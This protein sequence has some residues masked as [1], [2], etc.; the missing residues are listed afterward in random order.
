MSCGIV[1]AL[2]EELATLTNRKLARGECFSLSNDVLVAY[3]G[4]GPHNAAE[5]ARL[6]IA[7]GADRLI[8]WGCA[9]ALAPELRPG[10][11]VIADR[12]FFDQQ[13]YEADKCWSDKVSSRLGEKL[14]VGNGKL[15]TE[16]RI[17][18]LSEDKQAIHRNTGAM[19]L[20]MESGAIAKV[21]SQSNLPCLVLRAIAD[22]VAL[23]LPPAVSRAMN[24]Q[25]QVELGKLLRHLALHPW[26]VPALVKLGLHFHAAEK[27]L[28]TIARHLNEI[29][30]Y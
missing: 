5:A 8:S 6:L 24:E 13:I 4:A 18:A 26:E 3:A 14:A 16:T 17:V 22:P 12:I 28:K 29:A 9:A 20:D 30:I 1:V 23:D 11:L 19:A 27:T 7:K 2:P 15:V 10:Q 21:A 25:G